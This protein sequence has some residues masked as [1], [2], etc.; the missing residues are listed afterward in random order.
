MHLATFQ[1]FAKSFT[2]KQ[3]FLLTGKTQSL[4]ALSHS[5]KLTKMLLTS[6]LW[7]SKM[8]SFIRTL[9]MTIPFTIMLIVEVR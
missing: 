7:K 2:V 8:L 3:F 1:S 6:V 9:I 5:G 4:T